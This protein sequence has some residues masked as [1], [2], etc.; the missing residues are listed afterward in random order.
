MTLFETSWAQA[1]SALGLQPPQGLY[2]DLL[3]AYAEPQRHYHTQQ[4]LGEC[5][6]LLAQALPLAEHPGEVAVALWFHDAVYDVRGHSNE[7]LSADWARRA[8]GA[9]QASGETQR[10]VERLIMATRHDAAP[11]DPDAQLLVDLDLA[12]LGAAPA[13]FAE[14]DQQVRAEYRWVPSLVYNMNRK[15]VLKGFLARRQIYGTAF[16]RERFEAQARVNLAAA[17]G[18][19][20]SADGCTR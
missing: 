19:A 9:C 8:L 7:R 3:A 20:A 13:R 1:W 2:A 11:T 12:I 14:Y 5:L 4:H 6:A 15:R 17:I 18:R 16:A 10:R